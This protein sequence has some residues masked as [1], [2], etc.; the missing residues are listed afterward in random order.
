MAVAWSASLRQ[1]VVFRRNKLAPYT[2][3]IL[4][5]RTSTGYTRC[6]SARLDDT[7]ATDSLVRC[8]PP[9][10]SL[11]KNSDC[12]RST[13]WHRVDTLPPRSL[14]AGITRPTTAGTSCWRDCQNF[15]PYQPINLHNL[16]LFSLRH[17]SNIVGGMMS[18]NVVVQSRFGWKCARPD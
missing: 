5:R 14:A 9:H 1:Q 4:P 3:Q 12:S 15:T 6:S 17:R 8:T 11:R 10:R 18:M 16:T 13:N 2:P 7:L